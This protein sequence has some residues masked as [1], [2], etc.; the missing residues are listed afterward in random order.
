MAY[1][2]PG[3]IRELKN[4]IERLPILN[5][6]KSILE[7]ADF[8]FSRLAES[9]KLKKENITTAKDE[10]LLEQMMKEKG[11]VVEHRLDKIKELFLKHKRLTRNQIMA[12][13]KV[14][15]STATKDLQTLCNIGFIIKKSPTK[16]PRTDYFEIL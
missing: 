15:P 16:S 13:T 9:H 8:D 2:W 10:T 1:H 12:V 3:N 7:K 5:P 11:F 4:E 6:D 14:S